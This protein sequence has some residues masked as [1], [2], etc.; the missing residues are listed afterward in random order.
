MKRIFIQST[1]V[2]VI[3][4][5]FLS[6][7]WLVFEPVVFAA[8]N[9]SD[10]VRAQRDQGLKEVLNKLLTDDEHPLTADATS[11]L[12][13]QHSLTGEERY[14]E[15][16][17][18][19]AER[20][21]ARKAQFVEVSPG[22]LFDVAA[23]GGGTLAAAETLLDRTRELM[24]ASPTRATT[25]S[26][27]RLV[28]DFFKRARAMKNTQAF[29][30][31]L[32]GA[33]ALFASRLRA[34]GN[35]LHVIPGGSEAT[36]AS[37][38]DHLEVLNV[39][40]ASSEASGSPPAGESVEKL[41]HTILQRYWSSELGRLDIPG[42]EYAGMPELIVPV[43]NART[44]VAL[45][46][47]GHLRNNPMFKGR[48]QRILNAVYAEGMKAPESA[49]A[50][51]AAGVSLSETPIT[52]AIVGDPGLPGLG[53]LRRAAFSVKAP[54][55]VVVNLDPN[56]NRSQLE[57]LGLDGSQVAVY[58]WGYGFRSGALGSPAEIDLAVAEALQNRPS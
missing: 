11:L 7:G 31:A 2:L 52:I 25:D 33:G 48:A 9:L 27:G 5:L 20:E 47:A 29:S 26:Y 18:Q 21:L 17:K 40:I 38:S 32:S 6:L 37:L 10:T 3:S 15:R 45:W 50:V 19:M 55:R 23:A 39:A 16:A 14:L 54:H 8:P 34:S 28:T 56:Q 35:S 53:D 57:A 13:M 36:F 41:A 58:V 24:K 30:E 12:L 43:L 51:V 22:P 42:K 4:V 1:G 44:A 46:H 49:T